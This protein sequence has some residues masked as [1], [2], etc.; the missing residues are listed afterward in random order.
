MC[1]EETK[2]QE[3]NIKRTTLDECSFNTAEDKYDWML[4]SIMD[5]L[6]KRLCHFIVEY[7]FCGS[8]V[9]RTIKNIKV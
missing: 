8:A 6:I 2:K 7:H 5:F 9:K 1:Y 3:S 4:A